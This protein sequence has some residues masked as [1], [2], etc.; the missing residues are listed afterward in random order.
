MEFQRVSDR[1]L[2]TV[3]DYNVDLGHG[4]IMFPSAVDMRGTV[5]EPL[6]PFY[7]YL[8][9]HNGNAILLALADDPAGPWRMYEGNPVFR[10]EQAVECRAH[11]SSPEV[12]WVPEESRFR[13]YYHGPAAVGYPPGQHGS[14]AFSADG[15]SFEP[16][17]ANPIL[18][19]GPAGAWTEKMAAYQRVFRHD[20]RWYGLYMGHRGELHQPGVPHSVQLWAE[21]DDGLSWTTDLDHPVLGDTPEEG[22]HARVRHVGLIPTEDGALVFYCTYDSPAYDREVI[23]AARLRVNEGG[24]ELSRLGTVLV[25]ELDWERDELRDPCPLRVGER[26]YLYYIGGREQGLGLAVAEP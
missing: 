25:P 17:S 19:N 11:V 2:L 26:L 15:L 7:L 23:R 16:H 6:A 3:A 4:T 21:S 10:L 8:A 13:L 9:A 18:P 14:V 22:D 24:P 5:A 12:I 1:P 20:G